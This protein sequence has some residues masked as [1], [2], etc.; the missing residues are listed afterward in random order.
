MSG[1]L[2]HFKRLPKR[3]NPSSP[4]PT[5][6]PP[7]P[8]L[9]P[10]PSANLSSASSESEMSTISMISNENQCEDVQSGH[11]DVEVQEVL[12]VTPAT[13]PAPESSKTSVPLLDSF[14]DNKKQ[15]SQPVLD[16]YRG[17]WVRKNDDLIKVGI[18]NLNGWSTT[19]LRTRVSVSPAVSFLQI[20]QKQILRKPVFVIGRMQ[21]AVAVAVQER[22]RRVLIC[23]QIVNLTKMRC[24]CGQIVE[25]GR[26][27]VR[28]FSKRY[29]KYHR[30]S[31]N[32]CLLF[33]TLP[34]ILLLTGY[35]FRGDTEGDLE[36]DGKGSGFFQCAFSQHPFP[37][38]PKWKQVYKNLLKNAQYTSSTIQNEAISALA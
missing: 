33:S 36:R 9:S 14:F 16:S 26:N 21:K 6:P 12:S 31:N 30:R 3:S 19:K 11:M 1:I 10:R 28:Q 20:P 29:S 15:P 5:P 27:S 34:D 2:K 24:Y 22:R 18:M 25:G 8:P 37:L 23:M 17:K 35:L 38:E 13:N 7:P 4:S 32:G